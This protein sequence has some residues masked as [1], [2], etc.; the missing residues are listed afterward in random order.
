M[1]VPREAVVIGLLVSLVLAP[2]WYF[3]LSSHTPEREV[4]LNQSASNIAP[5]EK[6]M[7]TPAGVNEFVAGV[8]TWI[9]LF[10]LVGMIFYTHRF[11]RVI[12]R[13][14]DSI[15]ADGGVPLSLPPWL[16]SP[17]RRIAEY[18]PTRYS[19]PGMVGIVVMSWSTVTFAALFGMEALGYARTQYLGVYGGMMALSLGVLVA[20]YATWFIPS[21]VVVEE[22]APGEPFVGGGPDA[23]GTDEADGSSARSRGAESEVAE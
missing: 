22:R 4:V 23:G 16:G 5:T 15:A 14:T 6:F 20:V 18:W 21:T 7:P 13:A 12:G 8:I 11:V 2:T 17:H 3:A 1:K 19:T 9:A 10:V